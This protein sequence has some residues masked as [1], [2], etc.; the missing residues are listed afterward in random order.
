MI[1]GFGKLAVGARMGGAP[2]PLFVTK[3]LALVAGGHL[4]PGDCILRPAIELPH[5]WAANVLAHQFLTKTQADTLLMLDDDMIVEPEQIAALRDHPANFPFGMVQALCCSRKAPHSPLV[6]LPAQAEGLYQPCAPDAAE[7]TT[8]VGMVGLAATLIRRS[9]FE[10]LAARGPMF[11]AW[12][13][14]GKGEDA[15]FCEAARR[16]GVRIGV[17]CTVQVGHRIPVSVR[18]DPS[19]G[20]TVYDNEMNPGFIEIL[21]QLKE[22]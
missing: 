20:E 17:D 3:L 15:T 4:R 5:H 13:A 11:F 8:E 19:T 21:E 12:G 6:L 14:G 18:F 7:R 9:T 22:K 1:C 2:D 16:V 10:L